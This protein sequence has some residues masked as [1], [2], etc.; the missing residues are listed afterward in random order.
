M[1]NIGF[2][3]YGE[4]IDLVKYHLSQNKTIMLKKIYIAMPDGYELSPVISNDEVLQ[5]VVRVKKYN[6]K[7]STN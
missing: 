7:D 1:S 2:K 5:M 3:P 6:E 4:C